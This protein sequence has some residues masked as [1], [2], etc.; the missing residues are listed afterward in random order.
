MKSKKKKPNFYTLKDLEKVLGFQ[1]RTL[2]RY[3]KKGILQG[4]MLGR[5]RFTDEDVKKFLAKGKKDNSKRK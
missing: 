2:F 5:W 1:E 4:K 3:L